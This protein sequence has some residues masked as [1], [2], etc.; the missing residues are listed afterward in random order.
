M[1]KKFKTIDELRQQIILDVDKAE[2]FFKH[3]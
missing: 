2:S 1:K 3:E